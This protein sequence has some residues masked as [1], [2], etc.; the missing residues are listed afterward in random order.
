M[1]RDLRRTHEDILGPH[2][3]EENILCDRDLNQEDLRASICLEV[4]GLLPAEQQIPTQ[5]MA[6][7]L[8]MFEGKYPQAHWTHDYVHQRLSGRCC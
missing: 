2:I 4:P 5:Q 7:T 6:L 8:K 3:N 1:A